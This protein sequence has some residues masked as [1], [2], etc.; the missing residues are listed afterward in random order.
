MESIHKDDTSKT[1]KRWGGGIKQK[2]KGKVP[3]KLS[4]MEET[5]IFAM[6]GGDD[7]M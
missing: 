6:S 3:G 5:E 7:N 4:F 1:L 2:I